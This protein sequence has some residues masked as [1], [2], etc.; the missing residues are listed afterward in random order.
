MEL[1]PSQEAVSRSATQE[2]HNIL[3]NPEVHYRARKIQAPAHILSK[4]HPVHTTTQS[5]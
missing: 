2:F 3:W 4:I 5:V 1:G